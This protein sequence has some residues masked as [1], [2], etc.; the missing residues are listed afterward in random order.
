MAKKTIDQA[1]K[2]MQDQIDV[3]S[4]KY[5]ELILEPE[6]GE[7][8]EQKAEQKKEIQTRV[9]ALKREMKIIQSMKV[10]K[11]DKKKEREL[12]KMQNDTINWIKKMPNSISDIV[13]KIPKN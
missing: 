13:K 5:L 7:L 12:E 10:N 3:L 8:K 4:A 9:V 2:D 11:T 6:D 1:I